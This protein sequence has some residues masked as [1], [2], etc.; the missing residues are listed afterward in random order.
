MNDN[1]Y[2]GEEK[3]KEVLKKVLSTTAWIAVGVKLNKPIGT[4]KKFAFKVFT[5]LLKIAK[6]SPTGIIA[7]FTLDCFVYYLTGTTIDYLMEEIIDKIFD[8][9]N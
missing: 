6:F 7:G 8:V 4:I 1:K 9:F 5:K 2:S 3:Y